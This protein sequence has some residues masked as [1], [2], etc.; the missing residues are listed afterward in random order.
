MCIKNS[1]K[2]DTNYLHIEQYIIG[3]G[4]TDLDEI[5]TSDIG[6]NYID[7]AIQVDDTDIE[8]VEYKVKEIESTHGY[9]NCEKKGDDWVCSF[10]KI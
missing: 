7:K 8:I 2:T 3:T 9:V 10:Q 6:K 4:G 5:S 1:L